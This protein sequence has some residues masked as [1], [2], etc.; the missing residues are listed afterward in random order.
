MASQPNAVPDSVRKP[1]AVPVLGDN[2]PRNR[3][4]LFC[5]HSRPSGVAS[6]LLRLQKHFVGIEL[7]LATRCSF[8]KIRSRAV[9]VVAA[10]DRPSDIDDD[11]VP[12]FNDSIG[13]VV[14]RVAPLGPEPTM[15]KSTAVCSSRI[16]VCSASATVRSVIPGVSSEGTRA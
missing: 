9:G 12:C 11:D 15:M 10:R 1:L 14:M 16:A 2:V 8:D 5:S 7:L 3:V 13:E 6:C 4:E